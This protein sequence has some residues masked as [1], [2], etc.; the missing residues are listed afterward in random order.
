MIRRDLFPLL[1][2]G[3]LP[4]AWVKA[5]EHLAANKPQEDAPDPVHWAEKV[6]GKKLD[7]WQQS[8]LLSKAQYFLMNCSR[9]VG[10][11]EVV[12]LKA[13]YR[14]RHLGRRVVAIAP[15]L[16][17]SSKIRTRAHAFLQADGANIITANAITLELDNGGAVISLPGDRPDLSARSE[18]TDDLIV[19]EASRVRDSVIAAATPTTATRPNSTIS[20]LSTPAGKRG[21]FYRAWSEKAGA[22]EKYSV[23]ATQC[24]RIDAKFLAR[25]RALL[26]NLI[27]SQEYE[28]QF[29]ADS[30]AVLDPEA[31]AAMFRKPALPQAGEIDWLRE[32]P[33]T[34]WALV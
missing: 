33:K 22:W 18:T 9:Q 7:L 23:K 34:E 1:F 11:T 28:C 16:Y 2:P 5:M 27:F 3:V 8:Y 25:E 12:S 21:A 31:I 26:G 20:Y 6:S 17:Q 30:T 15:S 14:A 29:I 10:K 19:D 13:A 24:S 32:K 4:R